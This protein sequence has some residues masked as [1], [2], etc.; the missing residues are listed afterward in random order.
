MRIEL[1]AAD[2]HRL[3][4]W[5]VPA[6][7]AR[8]GGLVVL[9]EIFGVTDQL[10]GVA[11]RYAALG[12]DVVVPALFD[13]VQKETVVPFTEAPRGREMMLS[14]NPEKVIL[15]VDAAVQHLK[16]KGDNVGV[17]GFCWGGALAIRAAQILDIAAAVSFY[18][19]RLP[20]YQIAPIQ[21]PVQGHW[22]DA[23]G[24]VPADMLAAAQAFFPDMEVHLYPGAGHAFANDARPA[25]YIAEA[26][27]QAHKR[28]AVFLSKHM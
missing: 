7:G 21:V 16:A 13:R 22:G 17:I 9:Q 19:T 20:H 11:E 14:C 25:D 23:D 3:A 10:K 24:H 15:D 18:G 4:C 1:A 12:Y 5:M 28:T 26:A 8:K 2:G 27:E 6:E